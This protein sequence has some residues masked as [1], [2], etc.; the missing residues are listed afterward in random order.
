M[1][2]LQPEKWNKAF[3]TEEMT[4]RQAQSQ[5]GTKSVCYFG[6]GSASL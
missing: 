1:N 4:I 3:Q 2:R 6:K 5:E